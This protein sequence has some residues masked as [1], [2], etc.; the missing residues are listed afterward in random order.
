M[1]LYP[2]RPFTENSELSSALIYQFLTGIHEP[3]VK[4][5]ELSRLIE[6]RVSR[7]KL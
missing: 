7:I 3:D 1:Y 4:Q 2:N 6:G 5:E